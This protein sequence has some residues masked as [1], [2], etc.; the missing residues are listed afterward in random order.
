MAPKNDGSLSHDFV[1][2]CIE[3]VL[4][5]A[6]LAPTFYLIAP[7]DDPR[8]PACTLFA[9]LPPTSESLGRLLARSIDIQLLSDRNYADLRSAGVFGPLRIFVIDRS[10][11][12]PSAA[13]AEEMRRRGSSVWN[14]GSA[15]LDTRSG[16]EAV[17]A[18]DYV[19]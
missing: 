14:V 19:A 2:R 17:F 3:V 11:C 4:G 1:Q 8:T 7:S 15:L 13:F 5:A 12:E 18:G 9:D 16:W 10:R 6:G